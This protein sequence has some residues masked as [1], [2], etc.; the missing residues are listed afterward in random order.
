MPL[1]LSLSLSGGSLD[2][3]QAVEGNRATPYSNG[4]SVFVD[5]TETVKLLN[6][7]QINNLI[8]D[9]FTWAF[10]YRD[11]A[12]ATS[13]LGGIN[14]ANSPAHAI[15]I[16]PVPVAPGVQFLQSV[17]TINGS[18]GSATTSI[19]SALVANTWHH[20]AMVVTKG[21]G[22]ANTGTVKVY[23]DGVEK[24]SFA[25]PTTANQE[26]ANVQSDTTWGVGAAIEDDGNGGGFV[27]GFFDEVAFWN[28]ALPADDI[29]TIYNS[30]NGTSDLTSDFGSYNSSSNLQYYFRFEN[31]YTDTKGNASNA[32]TEGSPVFSTSPTPP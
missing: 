1:G 14:T 3:A 2:S 12:I 17:V 13:D 10:W 26:A 15:R 19:G 7:S 11:T 25:G 27:S 20:I 32:T 9:S 8:N 22:G 30:G 6:Q 21:S 23:I 18:T 29:G 4:H 31:D 28:A 5:G 16:R 24:Q